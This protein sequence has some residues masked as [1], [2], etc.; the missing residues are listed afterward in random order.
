[1]EGELAG[2]TLAYMAVDGTLVAV[3]AM[4][5]RARPGVTQIVR[6]LR[7]QG[8]QSILLT[9]DPSQAARTMAREAG[10][11]EVM[12]EIPPNRRAHEVS[13]TWDTDGV[14]AIGGDPN[15]D[16]ELLQ[17]GDVS[18]AVSE[19][20]PSGQPPGVWLVR[21]TFA[22]LL[23]AIE[24]ARFSRRVSYQNAAIS[25]IWSAL[26]VCVGALGI[27]GIH[28]PVIAGGAATLLFSMLS[29]SS[30]RLLVHRASR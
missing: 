3:F 2:Q 12:A 16:G 28:G 26:W 22:D 1:V 25:A 4:M 20:A 27:L 13:D 15:R 6:T 7:R 8:V 17:V 24:I 19:M 11:D 21:G 18:I 14:L 30:R 9:G 23:P 10:M 5:D 29:A